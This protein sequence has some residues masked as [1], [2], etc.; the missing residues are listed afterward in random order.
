MLAGVKH[1]DLGPIRA[2]GL[3][4]MGI[5]GACLLVGLVLLVVAERS[6]QAISYAEVGRHGRGAAYLAG[7]PATIGYV[8][9]VQGLYRFASGRGPGADSNAPLALVG[10]GLLWALAVAVF[11]AGAYVLVILLRRASA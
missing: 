2:A 1:L 11:F 5:G 9:S 3:R 4:M 10:R 6:D 7:L 8:L